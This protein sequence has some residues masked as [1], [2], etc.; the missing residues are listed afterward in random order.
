M[1]D[2]PMIPPYQIKVSQPA[3]FLRT[4]S[5]D[6]MLNT[7]QSTMVINATVV[8]FTFKKSA[9]IQPNNANTN[10]TA[11]DFSRKLIGPNSSKPFFAI[12]LLST[13]VNS[14]FAIK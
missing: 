6:T 1:P 2:I 14:G 7:T 13:L 8:E 10:K 4:S 12:A 11:N 5:Q 3:L 9:K